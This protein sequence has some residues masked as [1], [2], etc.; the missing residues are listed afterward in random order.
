MEKR[1][2]AH[3][4]S[5]RRTM[6]EKRNDEER[7][8]RESLKEAQVGNCQELIREGWIYSSRTISLRILDLIGPE[9][10]QRD[11]PPN[12]S[13]PPPVL[14]PGAGQ[15]GRRGSDPNHARTT[16]SSTLNHPAV[17]RA[18]RQTVRWGSDGQTDSARGGR[19]Y[20]ARSALR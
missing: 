4:I 6:M 10:R 5:Q 2:C 1:T 20:L 3:L 17:S 16:W 9:D 11:V 12:C 13:R 19:V 8:P 18:S 7:N 15:R 14:H